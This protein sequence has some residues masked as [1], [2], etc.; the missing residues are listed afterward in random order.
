[1]IKEG[2]QRDGIY[3][4]IR[5]SNCFND[6]TTRSF[7][8]E[9]FRLYISHHMTAMFFQLIQRILYMLLL[10]ENKKAFITN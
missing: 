10:M 8:I 3:I 7:E 9:C 4:F 1:M 5:L 2:N 6:L